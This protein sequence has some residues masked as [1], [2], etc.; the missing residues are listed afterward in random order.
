M[1]ADVFISYAR[2]G[3]LSQARGL[4]DRLHAAGIQTFHDERDIEHGSSFPADLARAL[5]DARVVVVLLDATYFDRPWCVFEFEVLTAAYRSAGLETALDHVI[6]ALPSGGDT[7]FVLAQLPPPIARRSWPTVDALE[8]IADLVCERLATATDR[9]GD[10]LATVNDDTVA[11]LRAGGDIPLAWPKTVRAEA[12]ASFARLTHLEL[13]PRSREQE[14]VGHARELWQVV[15]ALVTLRAF[16]P[17]RSCAVQGS[18]GT[19]KSQI[20]AEF[21][22]RYGS[23]F[24]PGGIVWTS[25]E[26]DD[27][28][29]VAQWRAIWSVVA[30]GDADPS[31]GS[32]D[33]HASARSILGAALHQ[34]LAE[35]PSAHKLLWIV[36]GL[37]E[38]AAGQPVN[39]RAWCPALGVSSVLITSRRAGMEDVQEHVAVGAL[40]PA[41]GLSLLTRPPVDRRWLPDEDWHALVQWVGGLPLALTILQASLGDGFTTA[42]ALKLARSGEASQQLD[43]EMDTL[44]EEVADVRLRSV[45]QTFAFSFQAL[46]DGS[47]LQRACRMMSLLS[48]IPI[49]ESVLTRL[50]EPALVGRLA[51]RSWIEPSGDGGIRRWSMHRVAASFLRVHGGDLDPVFATLFDRAG[52]FDFE[53]LPGSDQHALGWQMVHVRK[54][55]DRRRSDGHPMP[56]ATAA[57]AQ[58]AADTA[59]ALPTSASAGW[60]YLAA[61]IGTRVGADEQIA[62]RLLAAMTGADEER[63]SFVPQVIQPLTGAA[64]VDLMRRLLDDPRPLI[65]ARA[66]VHASSL[67]DLGL[68]QPLLARLLEWPNDNLKTSFDVYL[69]A[70]CPDVR[71]LI[72][73]LLR[74]ALQ[75]SPPVR[76]QRAAELLARAL[77][78]NAP[79]FQ[80]G[81]YTAVNLAGSL[82]GLAL[83]DPDD[84]VREAALS[85]A[86]TRFEAAVHAIFARAYATAD[87][88]GRACRIVQCWG[89]YLHQT[90]RP[91]MP[92][93]D[94]I[95]GE[96]GETLRIE[97][98]AASPLPSDA[99]DP[100][101][102]IASSATPAAA[103]AA[104]AILRSRAGMAAVGR[105]ANTALDAGAFA[106]VVTLS[107]RLVE[108]DESFVNSWWWR[109]QARRSLGETDGAL[110]DLARLELLTPD[111]PPLFALRGEILAGHE[112]FVGSATALERAVSLEPSDIRAQQ[113]LWFSLYRLRR[114]EEA[115]AAAA[116]A[117]DLVP[118][119]A[120]SWFERGVARAATGRL[121]EAVADLQ[122]AMQLAPEDTRTRDTLARV[123]AA[124]SGG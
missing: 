45:A 124:R 93:V 30:P 3:S 114:F 44:R 95:E 19:G 24:F 99:Y 77:A 76:R 57:A 108:A 71:A 74:E 51:K 117:I 53:A 36:D 109:A 63:L 65:Q 13:T 32:G 50:L 59:G 112:D 43:A 72:S 16:G 91:A 10:T 12:E 68:A 103:V 33:N 28:S 80:A 9:F 75:G 82:A 92:R 110:S 78:I 115:E 97:A 62:G 49:A 69:E 39:P 34:R 113:M 55:F 26:G 56:A 89:D 35:R 87:E 107:D 88:D 29:L 58:F 98:G 42:Q 116:R 5:E 41:A 14:F 111:F 48:G 46:G 31:A 40:S 118:G 8:P 25:A 85:G 17:V 104:K 70:R 22:A 101:I 60:R 73:Q 54:L 83:D 7:A 86:A 67:M 121:E 81:G 120:E 27:A 15:R 102:Q 61:S 47:S 119:N 64:A 18:G 23:S 123:E 6:V 79:D 94:R 96:A 52:T 11:R 21:V 2:G 106:R 1:G 20:A 90:Q 84:G 37:P 66:V 122:Q 38:A 100:L 105:A 4:R